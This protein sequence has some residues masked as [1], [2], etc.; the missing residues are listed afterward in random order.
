MHT[1]RSLLAI[2][3]MLPASA[4]AACASF[5][6]SNDSAQDAGAGGDAGSPATI[7]WR[8]TA[9]GTAANPPVDAKLVLPAVVNAVAGDFL[10]A[11]IS[12][13]DNSNTFSAPP[14]VSA[15]RGWAELKRVAR[16]NVTLAIV[17][18]KFF[19]APEPSYTWTV[20]RAITGVG[21]V[22][23]YA[24]VD[25]TNPIDA[26]DVVLG[27]AGSSFDAPALSTSLPGTMLVAGFFG[28]AP[29]GT[30]T[31]AWTLPA[32]MSA[33]AILDNGGTRSA[34]CA[35]VTLPAAGPTGPR[36]ATSSF[37][38]EYAL[39]FSVALRPALGPSR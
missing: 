13:G 14:V 29:G 25:P 15:P 26:N 32:S 6:T 38:L 5:G 12:L 22:S 10:V 18:S 7:T 34:A 11:A 39:T 23:A 21:C 19:S 37:P 28:K 8:G 20:D 17:Y 16:G 3:A 31:P 33:R 27:A 9:S 35:D 30:A 24:G 4:L 2:V 36:T 1:G